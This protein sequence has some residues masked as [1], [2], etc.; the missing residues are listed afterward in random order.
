MR[1]HDAANYDAGALTRPERL[2]ALKNSGLL[3][4]DASGRLDL[5]CETACTVLRVSLSMVNM[6]DE[7]FSVS[8]G[9]W[10]PDDDRTSPVEGVGCKDV[11]L[12]GQAVIVPDTLV[13][14]ILCMR[15]FVTV[16]G[17][18]SYLGVP[19]FF[20]GEVI[21]SFCAAD[22][23]VREWNHWDVAGLQGLARLAGL[24]VSGDV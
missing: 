15:P 14:P 16:M 20:D 24:A 8:V 13:H 1:A 12:T 18:R 23:A 19:V 22:Y 9:K 7:R 2:A 6:L 17:V 21:G 3:R 10:P 11:I 4:H 5:L